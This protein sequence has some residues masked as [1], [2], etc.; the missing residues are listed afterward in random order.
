MCG[1]TGLLAP[2]SNFVVLGQCG[3]FEVVEIDCHFAVILPVLD[4]MHGVLG[5]ILEA[6]EISYFDKHLVYRHFRLILT[7]QTSLSWQF[8][9]ENS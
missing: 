3:C 6:T 5:G 9:A 4:C 1:C 8:Q 2:A 7:A